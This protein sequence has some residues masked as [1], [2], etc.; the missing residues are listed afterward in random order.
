[1]WCKGQPHTWCRQTLQKQRRSAPVSMLRRLW[2]SASR[3]RYQQCSWSQ[4]QWHPRQWKRCLQHKEY[5]QMMQCQWSSRQHCTSGMQQKQLWQKSKFLQ[6]IAGRRSHQTCCCNNQLCI[7]SMQQQQRLRW[8]PGSKYQQNIA[9]RWVRLWRWSKTPGHTV[10]R[11]SYHTRCCNSQQCIQ[12]IGQQLLQMNKHQAS[13][14]G[15][16]N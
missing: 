14:A 1:M 2:H 10:C 11:Q 15:I 3:C 5:R 13:I 9:S 6:S 12:G 8:S 4:L 7:A 16:L